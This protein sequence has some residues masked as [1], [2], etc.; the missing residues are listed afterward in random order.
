VNALI[1]SL[2]SADWNR[3]PIQPS[4]EDSFAL[5]FQQGRKELQRIVATPEIER[6][7]DPLF[8]VP[9]NVNLVTLLYR[10]SK[11]EL[12]ENNAQMC[13]LLLDFLAIPANFHAWA[14]QKFDTI[15]LAVNKKYQLGLP[16]AFF[17]WTKW[18]V[19][20]EHGKIGDT[21]AEAVTQAGIVETLFDESCGQ[22]CVLTLPPVPKT[23]GH[24]IAEHYVPQVMNGFGDFLQFLYDKPVDNEKKARSL[25]SPAQ[26]IREKLNPSV[27]LPPVAE[28]LNQASTLYGLPLKIGDSAAFSAPYY[29]ASDLKV[30]IHR[31][32]VNGNFDFGYSASLKNITD[33]FGSRQ[34][35]MFLL[36][37]G[38][39]IIV[40]Y[41]FAVTMLFNDQAIRYD[42]EKIVFQSGTAGSIVITT[43]GYFV[44]SNFSVS[45][46][47]IV[48]RKI[49]KL[50]SYGFPDGSA[51]E[52]TSDGFS[53][54]A[55]R[56]APLL[57]V[58]TGSTIFVRSDGVGYQHKTDGTRRFEYCGVYAVTQGTEETVYDIPDF[59]LVYH[60]NG[61]FSVPINRFQ[62]T[63]S[64]DTVLVNC[65]EFKIE[66]NQK[67]TLFS[68]SITE[69]CFR[70]NR[71]EFKSNNQVLVAD[72][73]GE[74]RMVQTGL[75]IPQKKKVE[76]Y[77]THWGQGLPIKETLSE[78]QQ[79]DLYRLFLPRF[80]IVRPNFTGTEFVRFD[81]I[82]LDDV[83]TQE[84]HLPIRGGNA[85]NCI[86]LHHPQRP[87][88]LGLRPEVL[89]K[90]QRA[91][92]LK[93]LQVP[94]QK[95][96]KH[97]EV[98]ETDT[99]SEVKILLDRYL[100][101]TTEF[102]VMVSNRLSSAHQ[103]Y[104]NE[105]RPISPP[106]P[107]KLKVPPFTP[108]PR[109]LLMQSARET[110]SKPDTFWE[111]PEGI[112]AMPLDEPR[113]LPRPLSPR[114]LLCDPPRTWREERDD[115]FPEPSVVRRSMPVITPSLKPPSGK[116]RPMTVKADPDL[117]NFGSVVVKSHCVA[118]LVVTNVGSKPLHFCATQPN[119]PYVKVL[120]LPGVIFPG[121][122][123]TL[124]VAMDPEKTGRITTSFAL[125]TKEIC[126]EELTKHIPVVADVVGDEA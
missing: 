78:Q 18:D 73:N 62:C 8:L 54:V 68:A 123:M 41:P 72:A 88:I 84:Y 32:L 87:P 100:T 15:V 7:P 26:I 28:R 6:H 105:I 21:L 23:M 119:V 51:G 75:D 92:L 95:K 16:M 56:Q 38:I 107:E 99:L 14:G 112:F 22:L 17:E 126:G 53:R 101:E 94:K 57:D 59:P 64:A 97:E 122:K 36:M 124:K 11:W 30:T 45:P 106:P 85:C 118:S 109:L 25:P 46:S 5:L 114:V 27:L 115:P 83:K 35:V 90:A 12:S 96:G 37:E 117:I 108:P 110:N 43:D 67:M 13:H 91:A 44:M 86:T 65:D 2:R 34:S 89:A 9:E 81:T 33:V 69:M 39:R 52:F 24:F 98:L 31:D 40:E 76:V 49:D 19:M 121:M 61:S 63:F 79:L 42:P 104:L 47:G 103:V 77:E 3:P 82:P 20:I 120:T 71:C 4:L 50:W 70:E 74:E 48:G 29:F 102:A 1:H 66:I 10:V 60:R 116:S 111:S 93:S 125:M 58:S 80:F 113:V 55:S